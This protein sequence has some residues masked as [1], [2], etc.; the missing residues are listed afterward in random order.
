MA[1]DNIS[2]EDVKSVEVMENHQPIKAL[3]GIEYPEEAGINL[4]LKDDAKGR[5]V[6]VT[7]AGSGLEPLLYDGS[8]YAMR[9]APK[10]Q[11]ILTLRGGNTGWNPDEQVTDHDFNDMSF[12]DYTESLWPEYISADII[13]A[14]LNEKRTRDSRSWLANS[15]TAWKHGDAS[16]RVT[17]NYVGERLDFNSSVYTDYFSNS[18]PNFSQN[19]SLSSRFQN[20]S[21]Q[22][23]T[24]INKRG[25]F[26]KN[27][28]IAKAIDEKSNSD[29]TGSFDLDQMI[30]RRNMSVANDLKLVKRND[31]KLFELTSRNSFSYRPD[32]LFIDGS[33][34]ITQNISSTDFRSTTE[35][36]YG[37]LGRFWKF[38]QTQKF[39]YEGLNSLTNICNQI[40]ETINKELEISGI[41]ATMT[42]GTNMSKNTLEL[43]E[44]K[45]SKMMYNT[46]IHKSITAA[47]S[48][49]LNRSLC[50]NKNRLGDEYKALA[51]ELIARC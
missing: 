38:Y 21:V 11:N 46:S 23:N 47:N 51:D 5:W 12:S 39:A 16:M 36:R 31:K 44:N 40:K 34:N 1:T 3:E 27:K 35:T 6:G 43:L 4:K 13:N 19:N 48:T 2:Y 15:I 9:I 10:V 29:I 41:V 25:Y 17:L 30:S 14:P 20:L 7:K 37:K 8:V 28:I 49:E 18:I 50:L 26:L 42:D 32:R 45:Y 24:Q 22:F 33:E